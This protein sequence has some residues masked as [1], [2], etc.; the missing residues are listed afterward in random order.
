MSEAPEPLKGRPLTPEEEALLERIQKLEAESPDRLE[1]AARQVITL[2]TGL[3]GLFLG[4]LAFSDAPDYVK[5]VPVR[6]LS[7]AVLACYLIALGAALAVVFPRRTT[8]PRSDLTAMAEAWERLLARKS[9]F[10]KVAV[11]AFGAGTLALGIAI[12]VIVFSL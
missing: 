8:Y 1:D 9:R 6:W 12:A 11:A 3:L 10:L 2:V 7:A 4:V 5:L